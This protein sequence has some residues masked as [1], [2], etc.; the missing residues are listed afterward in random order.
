MLKLRARFI[1]HAT[2]A[3]K[4]ARTSLGGYGSSCCRKNGSR[5]LF[6]SANQQQ[7]NA[8]LTYKMVFI[9]DMHQN[10]QPH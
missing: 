2:L 5:P 8:A 3:C 10:N 4:H 7:G 6:V 1:S 9:V